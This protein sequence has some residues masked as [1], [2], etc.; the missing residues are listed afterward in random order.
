MNNLLEYKKE[1][2]GFPSECL[3]PTMYLLPFGCY[4]FLI[5]IIPIRLDDLDVE[6][7]SGQIDAATHTGQCVGGGSPSSASRN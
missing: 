3:M 5:R 7:T 6:R 2:F 1:G 4:S